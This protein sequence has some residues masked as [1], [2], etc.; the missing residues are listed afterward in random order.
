MPFLPSFVA[1]HSVACFEASSAARYVVLNRPWAVV[2]WL[3][4]VKIPE[5]YVLMSEPDH[6]WLKPMPNLMLGEK[7]ASYPF[8]YI[9]PATAKNLPL[10]ETFTGKLTRSQAESISPIGKPATPDISSSR[11]NYN[12]G[13]DCQPTYASE[14]NGAWLLEKM[15]CHLPIWE[16]MLQTGFQLNLIAISLKLCL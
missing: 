13:E 15:T 2:Q 8:F 4:E 14:P 11:L 1:W 7:P 3:R 10:V 12:D 9:E 16:V 5:R 6:I